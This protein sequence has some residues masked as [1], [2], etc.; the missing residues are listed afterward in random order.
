LSSGSDS[1]YFDYYFHSGANRRNVTWS[2]WMKTMSRPNRLPYDLK[3]EL[4]AEK[5]RIEKELAESTNTPVTTPKSSKTSEKTTSKVSPE[6]LR[7]QL[8]LVNNLISKLEELIPY[9]SQSTGQRLINDLRQ[10]CGEILAEGAEG[11]G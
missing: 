10:E 3:S 5:Q 4:K 2:D 7:L 1:F 11:Q 8:A 6:G 9:E